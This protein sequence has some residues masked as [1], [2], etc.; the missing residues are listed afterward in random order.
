MMELSRWLILLQL[1]FDL[2]GRSRGL[3]QTTRRRGALCVCEGYVLLRLL[4][5][6]HLGRFDLDFL[7]ERAVYIRSWLSLCTFTC[8][9]WHLLPRWDCRLLRR[10][11]T[12]L[13]DGWCSLLRF[14]G[15]LR[16]RID[17]RLRGNRIRLETIFGFAHRFW[18]RWSCFA[19]L[20]I[21][22][23]LKDL[24]VIGRVCQLGSWPSWL[25]SFIVA[26]T[27]R[28]LGENRLILHVLIIHE[29]WFE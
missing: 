18:W 12:F 15:S 3:S 29:I 27:R 14:H 10:F 24:I 11:L 8:H 9:V 21:E 23:M 25:L 16:W 2:S 5:L 7:L 1:L 17:L 22:R 13:N 6:F 28:S 26:Y 4:Y 19:H 20:P